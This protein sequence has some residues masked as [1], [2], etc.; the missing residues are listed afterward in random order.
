MKFI[1]PGEQVP[2]SHWEEL[3]EPTIFSRYVAKQHFVTNG[4]RLTVTT[5][6]E[7]AQFLV[8][9]NELETSRIHLPGFGN[10]WL[11][12]LV[13]QIR[14]NASQQMS[15]TTETLRTTCSSRRQ[16]RQTDLS[17]NDVIWLTIDGPQT[18][19]LNL[20][21]NRRIKTYKNWPMTIGKLHTSL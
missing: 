16:N 18:D 1:S 3:P 20:T 21:S 9:Q 8:G 6:E 12:E 7:L 4:D 17:Q 5:F 10:D 13:D 15:T 2:P 19:R 14:K 11:W